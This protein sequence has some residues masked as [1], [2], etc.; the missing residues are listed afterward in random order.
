MYTLNIFLITYSQIKMCIF[1][2]GACPSRSF[3]GLTHR[4]IENIFSGPFSFTVLLKGQ[5]DYKK[6][7]R[8]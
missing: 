6:A 7:K 1:C 3:S 2:V 5:T 8:S 4:D